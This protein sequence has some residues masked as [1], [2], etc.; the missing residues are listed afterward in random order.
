M[1]QAEGVEPSVRKSEKV[2]ERTEF[3]EANRLFFKK[4][5]Y[6]FGSL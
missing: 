4:T 5:S 1:Y 3:L 2:H 6:N